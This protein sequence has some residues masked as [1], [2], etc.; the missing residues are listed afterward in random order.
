MQN[1]L[2]GVMEN[3]KELKNRLN[4]MPHKENCKEK[5]K[6]ELT[7][8]GKFGNIIKLSQDSKAH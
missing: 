6:R 4:K 1:P 2:Y 8:A 5:Q 7:G 3:E